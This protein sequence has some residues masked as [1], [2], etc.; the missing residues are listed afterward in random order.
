M[1]P[2]SMEQKRRPTLGFVS[3]TQ[4]MLVLGVTQN[5]QST[6]RLSMEDVNVTML[7]DG[8]VTYVTGKA[9]LDCLVWTAQEEVTFLSYLD[10]E[11]VRRYEVMVM[12][13][14]SSIS[15]IYMQIYFH[16]NMVGDILKI[17]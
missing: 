13:L 16:Y 2:V 14:W 11:M 6:D 9:V 1:N 12:L 8:K 17:F 7:Q 10:C 3:V 15:C 5:A 4:A